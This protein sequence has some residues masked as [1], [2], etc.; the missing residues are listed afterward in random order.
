VDEPE[1]PEIVYYRI[2]TTLATVQDAMQHLSDAA[3]PLEEE[4]ARRK[5]IAILGER[6]CCVTQ[7]EEVTE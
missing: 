7:S 2:Q 1:N 3:I 6:E 4:V 5:L